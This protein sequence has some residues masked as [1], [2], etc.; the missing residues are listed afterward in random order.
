MATVVGKQY[1]TRQATTL[2]KFAQT[3][4][5]PNVAAGLVEKAADL[6]SQVDEPNRPDKSPRA[7][8]VVRSSGA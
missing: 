5:D 7:P 1:L 4:T 3:V 2:L 6:K 8:D